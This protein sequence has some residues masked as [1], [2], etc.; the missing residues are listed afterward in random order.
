MHCPSG[1]IVYSAYPPPINRAQT[2]SPILKRLQDLPTATILPETSNPMISGAPGGTGYFPSL[3]LKSAPFT[4]AACTLINTS[5]LPGTG[6][7]VLNTDS[8]SGPP[9]D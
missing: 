2:K 4:P 1:A 9:G 8:A 5:S 3:S 7:G 6:I